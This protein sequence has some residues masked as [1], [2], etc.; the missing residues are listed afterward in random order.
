MQRIGGPNTFG[1]LY[2]ASLMCR[3]PAMAVELATI[4][5]PDRWGQRMLQLGQ[6]YAGLG[7]V[8]KAYSTYCELQKEIPDIELIARIG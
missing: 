3:R 6:W 1:Q 2:Y 4:T 8:D 7:E 5:L